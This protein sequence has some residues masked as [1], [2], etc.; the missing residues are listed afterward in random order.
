MTTAGIVSK[1]LDGEYMN[2][3]SFIPEQFETKIGVNV[4]E[5][6]RSIERASLIMSDDNRYPVKLIVEDDRC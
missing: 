2:Y 3:R 1:V 6:T 4:N 5:I